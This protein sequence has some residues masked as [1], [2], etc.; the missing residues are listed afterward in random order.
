VEFFYEVLDLCGKVDPNLAEPV[1]LQ[2]L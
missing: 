2:H 1:K